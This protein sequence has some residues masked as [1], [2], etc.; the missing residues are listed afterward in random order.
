[1]SVEWPAAALNSLAFQASGFA[2]WYGVAPHERLA[3]RASLIRR[4]ISCWQFGR[5]QVVDAGKV[6][7]VVVGVVAVATVVTPA[8]TMV[9]N[10]WTD[11]ALMSVDVPVGP[12]SARVRAVS[13]SVLSAVLLFA[14]APLLGEPVSPPPPQAVSSTA[15]QVQEI[16]VSGKR[17]CA[18]CFNAIPFAH[19]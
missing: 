8:S 5:P 1:M 2:G 12:I 11:D 13:A 6:S 4:S 17:C 3:A 19:V 9:D 18:D 16:R 15:A 10:G 7:V 14:A